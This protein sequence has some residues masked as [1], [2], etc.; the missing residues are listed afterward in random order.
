VGRKGYDIED[1][2]VKDEARV[3][4]RTE[5]RFHVVSHPDLAMI[6]RHWN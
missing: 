5:A 2:E 4:Y 6:E 3:L 1:D